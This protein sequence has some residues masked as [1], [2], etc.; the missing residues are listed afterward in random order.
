[1]LPVVASRAQ[2]I[3]TRVI[4]EGRTRLVGLSSAVECRKV[5]L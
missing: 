4:S 5:S 3:G 2:D 1:M